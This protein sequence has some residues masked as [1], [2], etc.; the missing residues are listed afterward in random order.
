MKKSILFEILLWVLIVTPLIYLWQAWDALPERV[1]THWGASG[2]PNGWSDRSSLPWMIGGLGIGMYLL[3]LMLFGSVTVPLAVLM[4]L[5][6]AIVG[7]LGAMALTRSP[8]TLP[9]SL[10]TLPRKLSSL[11]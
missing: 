4:S 2:E 10:T 6:L 1:A 11:L 8:F 3:M 7:A 5:P 9:T